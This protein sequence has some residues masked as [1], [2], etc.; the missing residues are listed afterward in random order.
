MDDLSDIVGH[1]LADLVNCTNVVNPPKPSPPSLV[2]ALFNGSSQNN[3]Q[4]GG[5]SILG[6]GL[7]CNSM[8]NLS[9]VT[10]PN[11]SPDSGNSTSSST[12][13][14]SSFMSPDISDLRSSDLLTNLSGII[15]ID[16]MFADFQADQH[17]I[18]DQVCKL[19]LQRKLKNGYHYSCA[20][21]DT[22]LVSQF[23]T[24]SIS[25]LPLRPPRLV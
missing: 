23:S 4:N 8:P 25:T 11:H 14:S 7:S 1:E 10:L 3:H 19:E 18:T 2:K 13:S 22:S 6:N 16:K 24:F 5:G 12:S 21:H 20:I 15:D 17:Q 9:S